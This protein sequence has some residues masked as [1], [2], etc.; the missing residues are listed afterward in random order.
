LTAPACID[1]A[2]A[3]TGVANCMSM[4]AIDAEADAMPRPTR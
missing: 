3:A 1:E 4:R 2:R